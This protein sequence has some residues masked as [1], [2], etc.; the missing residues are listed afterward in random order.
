MKVLFMLKNKT[1]VNYPFKSQRT[2]SHCITMHQHLL[3]YQSHLS[4]H[5][6]S[7][8]LIKKKNISQKHIN[9]SPKTSTSRN[10]SR[11]QGKLVQQNRLCIPKRENSTKKQWLTRHRSHFRLVLEEPLLPRNHGI[12]SRLVFANLRVFLESSRLEHGILDFRPSS[13]SPSCKERAELRESLPVA[14]ARETERERETRIDTVHG[15]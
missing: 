4:I 13:T 3:Y 10:S 5:G 2:Y 8:H 14:R 12:A 15:I 11:L 7:I 1:F 9:E 6:Y